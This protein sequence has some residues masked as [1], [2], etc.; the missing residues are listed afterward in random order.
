VTLVCEDG[1]LVE[2]HRIVL[3]SSSMFF[4]E[5]LQRTPATHPLIYMRGVPLP[6]LA[7]VVDFI[8]HGEAEVLKEHLDSFLEVAGEL[9][10]KGMTKVSRDKE[11]AEE[12]D[13]KKETIEETG[14]PRE[15]INL[16]QED[17]ELVPPVEPP[18]QGSCALTESEKESLK[19]ELCGKVYGTKASLRTHKY[20]HAKKNLALSGTAVKTDPYEEK[21]LFMPNEAEADDLDATIGDNTELEERIDALTEKKEGLWTCIQCGKTDRQRFHLRRHAETHI[22][23]FS[24]ACNLCGKTFSQRAHLKTHAWKDHP[25]EKPFSCEIC[26]MPSKSIALL[27][28]HKQRKHPDFV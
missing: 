21:S 1:L 28:V 2:A 6:T 9:G 13:D 15:V 14:D 3:A 16:E 7:A 12:S 27:K 10:V 24:H 22:E 17:T 20:N 23:G 11:L 18:T 5:V 25:E 26:N 19:C 8:Y 4:R